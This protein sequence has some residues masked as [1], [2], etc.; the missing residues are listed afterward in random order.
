MRD[1]PLLQVGTGAPVV[2]KVMS[3]RRDELDARILGEI[4]AGE[5][6]GGVGVVDGEDGG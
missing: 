6:A 5:V 1:E 4:G 3:W 2:G